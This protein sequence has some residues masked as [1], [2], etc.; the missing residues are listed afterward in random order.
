MLLGT[1]HFQDPGLDVY[2]PQLEFDILSDKRQR[3]VDEVVR[4][5]AAFRPT[6]VAVER[7]REYQ[8]KTDEDYQAYRRGAFSLSGDEVHQPGFRLAEVVGLEDFYAARP[9]R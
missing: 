4:R 2:K 5:L 8:A 6:K 9:R 1:F 3:E 7:R